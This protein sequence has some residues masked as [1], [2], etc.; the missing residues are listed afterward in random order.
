MTAA[1]RW[2]LVGAVVLLLVSLPVLVRA[3]PAHDA[4]VSAT[5]LLA[6]V[7]ASRDVAFSGYAET[8]GSVP[9]PDNAELESLG[10]LLGR[11]NKERVW[12]RDPSTWR[13][14][15][16]RTTGE[17]DLW[18]SGNRML[19]WEYES[20]SV[21][22]VPDRDV[23][24]PMTADL[25]PHELARR[26]L[27]G[28]RPGEL[29]RIGAQRVAGRDALGL[30]LVP[31]DPQSSIGRVDVYVDRASGLP[32]EVAM[33]GRHATRPSLTTRFVDLRIGAPAASALS[34]S[35]P[36]DAIF[37]T[38]EVVDIADAANRF[39]SRVPPPT[40]AGLAQ[41]RPPSGVPGSVGVY[42]RG[43]TVLIAVP[44][45]ERSATRVR[46]DLE[47]KPGARTIDAGVLVTTPPLR[48]L[49]T[50][51]E[52][53]GSAWLLA[54]TVTRVALEDAAAQLQASPPGS[55]LP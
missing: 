30:R 50:E 14:A 45:W 27:A 9:L 47:G 8:A 3:L 15:T 23:R 29:S 5:A 31:S 12:W 25:L 49:L 39:A 38:D 54:G 4:E 6:R 11:T 28:A 17:T 40:M 51:P 24:L 1:R 46:E 33:F 20:R 36:R 26:V 43:P 37:Q 52:R 32:L 2:T 21:T 48:L 7:R 41:R 16:L 44:L 53:S 19:R 13:V 10:K 35:P 18:H 42:G 22:L 34:F 55:A